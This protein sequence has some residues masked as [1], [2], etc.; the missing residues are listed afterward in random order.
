MCNFIAEKS[1]WEYRWISDGL[2]QTFEVVD[3]LIDDYFDT[4]HV[5]FPVLNAQIVKRLYTK[6]PVASSKTPADAKAVIYAVAALAAKYQE[7]NLRLQFEYFFAEAQRA[8]SGMQ[9]DMTFESLLAYTLLVS[10]L[11]AIE[12][13]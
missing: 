3:K 13:Y 11:N 12:L 10:A 7:H 6:F 4:V 9:N 8:L 2:C 1:P 5:V